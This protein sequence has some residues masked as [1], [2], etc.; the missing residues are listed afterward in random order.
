MTGVHCLMIDGI[1]GVSFGVHAKNTQMYTD[2]NR[3]N[4]LQSAK[5]NVESL[6][7][8]FCISMLGCVAERGKL[9]VRSGE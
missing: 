3:Q 8:S 5:W 4:T 6:L 7:K 1:C 2:I 9:S